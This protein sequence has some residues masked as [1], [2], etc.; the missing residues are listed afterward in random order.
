MIL[1]TRFFH[2][3]YL[4][5][6]SDIS[7]PIETTKFSSSTSRHDILLRQNRTQKYI[8]ELFPRKNVPLIMSS[9]GIQRV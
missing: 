1:Q 4:F 8:T 9:A 2:A 5:N 3:P 6:L 7:L